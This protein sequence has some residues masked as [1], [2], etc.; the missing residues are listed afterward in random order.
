MAIKIYKRGNMVRVEDS[1]LVDSHPPVPGVRTSYFFDP[2]GSNT[3]VI[4]DDLNENALYKGLI[5]G[6]TTDADALI[7]DKAAGEIYLD[8]TLGA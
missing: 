5:T 7:A 3:V 8:D 2:P 6:I 4:M 1:A